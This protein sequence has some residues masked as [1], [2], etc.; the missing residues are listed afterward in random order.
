MSWPIFT[1]ADKLAALK[2]E[3]TVE[4]RKAA[5]SCAASR[6]M[7]RTAIAGRVLRPKLT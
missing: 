3:G 4:A 2:K 1:T 5:P 6:T 7:C